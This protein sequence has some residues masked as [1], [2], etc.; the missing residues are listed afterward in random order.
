MKHVLTNTL[1]V[2]L[3]LAAQAVDDLANA[4]DAVLA[5]IVAELAANAELLGVWL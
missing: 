1:F 5:A 4:V 2:A 3:T